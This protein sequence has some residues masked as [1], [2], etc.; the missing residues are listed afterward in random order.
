MKFK[1]FLIVGAL[2]IGGCDRAHDD[3]NAPIMNSKMKT[4]LLQDN[5]VV[6]VEGSMYF[7]SYTNGRPVI[8]SPVTDSTYRE[9]IRPCNGGIS[10]N[11]FETLH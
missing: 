9:G 5:S 3:T 8:A 6:C 10:L 4:E 11:Q 2:M 1:S 7:V